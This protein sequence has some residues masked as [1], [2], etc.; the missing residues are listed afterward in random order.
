MRTR[1][2]ILGTCSAV[3]HDT[4][5]GAHTFHS[6]RS[7]IFAATAPPSSLATSATTSSQLWH[8]IV[9]VAATSHAVSRQG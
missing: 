3:T 4:T 9:P 8:R 5:P 6:Q 7:E 1:L 2:D